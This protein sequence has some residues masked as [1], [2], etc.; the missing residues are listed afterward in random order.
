MCHEPSPK[1]LMTKGCISFNS[2][3]PWAVMT[4]Q[5]STYKAIS[6]LT[7]N[8]CV[9]E[10]KLLISCL[11]KCKV[12]QPPALDRKKKSNISIKVNGIV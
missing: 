8:G 3:L 4:T 9:C 2:S 6:L 11:R 10:K 7:V 12:K 5:H 1:L